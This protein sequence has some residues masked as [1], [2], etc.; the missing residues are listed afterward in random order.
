MSLIND[1]LKKAQKQRTGGAPDLTKLP[2]IGGEAPARIAKRDKPPAFN[3]LI[4]WVG[5]GPATVLVLA[6]GGFFL[7][8][9]MMRP[10]EAQPSTATLTKQAIVAGQVTPGA[11]ETPFPAAVQT[12]VPATT[13][14]TPAVVTVKAPPVSEVAVETKPVEVAPPVSTPSPIEETK[15]VIAATAPRMGPKAVAFIDAL[16]VAGVRASGTD[17][18]VLMNDRVYRIGDTVE[19]VLGLKLADITA[20]S[21]TFE[22]ENGARY[23][24]KL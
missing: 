21:L 3:S 1:A 11:K 19:H 16:H 8:R 9:W 15:P 22:D 13:A 12:A 5:A 17:S 2:N 10:P 4:L 24:R 7:I 20:E 23:T 6:V 14:P 18:K